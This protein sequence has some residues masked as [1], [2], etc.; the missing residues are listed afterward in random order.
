MTALTDFGQQVEIMPILH[1]HK[2]KMAKKAVNAFRSSKYSTSTNGA[3]WYQTAK[4]VQTLCKCSYN[5]S[6]Q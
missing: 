6:C 2:E 3:E 4:I 1:M 5:I